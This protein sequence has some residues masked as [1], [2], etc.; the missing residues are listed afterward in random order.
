MMPVAGMG[1]I[2]PAMLVRVETPPPS[3]ATPGLLDA[4]LCARRLSNMLLLGAVAIVAFPLVTMGYASWAARDSQALY[5]RFARSVVDDLPAVTEAA[6][7]QFDYSAAASAYGEQL[8]LGDPLG[9]LRIHRLGLDAIVRQGAG[10]MLIDGYDGVLNLGPSHLAYSH[11]PGEG[12]NTAI[13]GH[14]T[15]YTH[16]FWA[17]NEMRRGDRIVMEV[18]YGTFR[19]RVTRVFEVAPTDRSV[20]RDHGFEQLTL[21]TCTPRH[22]ATRRLIVQATLLD[23]KPATRALHLG[24]GLL[25]PNV[26]VDA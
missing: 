4:R 18:P 21:S 5:E 25:P 6:D 2:M 17:L 26:Q 15:T 12:S 10:E 1:P 3:P 11:L 20:A 9:R 16:P 14:R 24:K 22:S 19:Y 8:R 23:T 13:A 7:G